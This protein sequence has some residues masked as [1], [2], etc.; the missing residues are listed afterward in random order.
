M[1]NDRAAAIREEAVRLFA[2][3]GYDATSMR[4]IATAVGLLPGSLYAH[5]TSKEQLLLEIIEEGIHEFLTAVTD[6]ADDHQPAPA[7]LRRAIATHLEVIAAGRDRTGVVFHQWRSLTGE[8]RQRVLR[9]RAAYEQHFVDILDGGVLEGS[10][11]PTL[12]TRF[13]VLVILGALNWAPEWFSPTGYR[14]AQEIADMVSDLLLGGLGVPGWVAPDL[15]GTMPA[16]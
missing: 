15:G 4:D 3:Q 16:P 8:D 2:K 5:I 1:P 11:H 13:A 9:K 7:R 12:D 6:A 10:F 14:T